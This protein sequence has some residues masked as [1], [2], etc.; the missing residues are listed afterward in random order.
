M[1]VV[2]GGS[3]LLLVPM[4][5]K[6]RTHGFAVCVVSIDAMRS[7]SDIVQGGEQ[8]ALPC[9]ALGLHGWQCQVCKVSAYTV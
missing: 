6:A 9:T 8:K 2:P 4:P 7:A 5:G 1:H 3:S